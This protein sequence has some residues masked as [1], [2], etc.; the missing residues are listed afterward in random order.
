VLFAHDTE[1]GL[2]AA[3]ALVNTAGRDGEQLADLAALD[4][5]TRAWE[6]TGQRTHDQAELQAVRDLRPRL[7][8][9]WESDE[10]QTVAIV[11]SLLRDANALPQLIR[12]GSW[13]YHLH[14][15]RPGAALATRM[16]VEAAMA[17]LDLVR[18]GELSRLRICAYTGCGNVVVDLSKNKSKRYCDTGCSNRA[19]V[20]AYRARQRSDHASTGR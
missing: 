9:L 18:V 1:Q 3:A 8:Q 7:R 17:F 19:A 11:N 2:A 13:G 4:E 14:A 12:H 5:F 10:E 15:T 20:D 16:A 6:W